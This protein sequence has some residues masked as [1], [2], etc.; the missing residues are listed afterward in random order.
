MGAIGNMYEITFMGECHPSS[1]SLNLIRIA[2]NNIYVISFIND[3]SSIHTII[4]H[5]CVWL[6]HLWSIVYSIGMS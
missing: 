4:F 3:L 5:P 1:M 2:S 6:Q